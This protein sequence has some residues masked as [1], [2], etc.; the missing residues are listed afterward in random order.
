MTCL[1]AV[2]AVPRCAYN[3][4]AAQWPAVAQQTTQHAA[5]SRIERSDPGKTQCPASARKPDMKTAGGSQH[6]LA[7]DRRWQYGQHFAWPI[8]ERRRRTAI[9][10][11]QPVE[12]EKAPVPNR[13]ARR[14][15]SLPS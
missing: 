12:H 11:R 9:D 10:P 6:C 1:V 3:R 5:N 7:A 4:I 15:R 8:G 2:N 14:S 13:G